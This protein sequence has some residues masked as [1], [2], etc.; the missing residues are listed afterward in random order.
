MVS[1]FSFI[2]ENLHE[3]FLE[4]TVDFAKDEFDVKFNKFLETYFVTVFL[5]KSLLDM[6]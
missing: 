3:W 5:M 1:L 2:F 6:F 4:H